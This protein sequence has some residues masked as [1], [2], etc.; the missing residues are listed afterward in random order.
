MSATYEEA[1]EEELSDLE[2][3][4]FIEEHDVE[5]GWDGFVNDVGNKETYTGKEV[6]DW[7]NY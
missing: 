7:L 4:A 6:L 1:I 2:A 5:G 3:R